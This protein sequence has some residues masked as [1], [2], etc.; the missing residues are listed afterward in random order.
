MQHIAK[1]HFKADSRNSDEFRP[2]L[3]QMIVTTTK[4]MT[5]IWMV[6]MDVHPQ[7]ILQSIRPWATTARTQNQ[8]EGG[9][10]TMSF[11]GDHHQYGT[12]TQAT[13]FAQQHSHESR[14]YEALNAPTSC[15]SV[16][17]TSLPLQRYLREPKEPFRRTI[18]PKF[19]VARE[20][21]PLSSPLDET[22]NP[23]HHVFDSARR[24]DGNSHAVQRDDIPAAKIFHFQRAK[25]FKVL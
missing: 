11:S 13:S 10:Q 5:T 25:V 19:D 22:S 17:K 15:L 7:Y 9:H 12:G 6:E 14:A 4:I 3:D 18:F 23:L 16:D 2:S 24:F 21:S 8:Q 1:L 20:G